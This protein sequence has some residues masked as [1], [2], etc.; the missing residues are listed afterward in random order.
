MQL[1]NS[2]HPNT[3]ANYR[4]YFNKLNIEGFDF[5]NGFKCSDVHKFEKF[6]NFSINIIELNFYQDQNKRRQKLV[7]IEI[8]KNESDRIIDLLIH[9]I[10]YV[11][12]NK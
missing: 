1:C 10:Y 9:K 6:Y 12:L 4:Q 3:V 7:P 5:S 2:N 8:S 11:L